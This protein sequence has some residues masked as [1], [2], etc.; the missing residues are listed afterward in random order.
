[1]VAQTEIIDE[2]NSIGW[3]VAAGAVLV[4]CV[5]IVFMTYSTAMRRYRATSSMADTADRRLRKLNDDLATLVRERQFLMQQLLR[6][7]GF[8]GS[9]LARWHVEDSAAAAQLDKDLG[10]Q[11]G[12]LFNKPMPKTSLSPSEKKNQ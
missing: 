12:A 2:F 3:Y 7:G 4:S 8:E 11:E 10:I 6:R 5:L 9:E 1:M